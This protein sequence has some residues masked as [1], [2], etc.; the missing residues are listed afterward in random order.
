MAMQMSANAA[1]ELDLQAFFLPSSVQNIGIM[2][3]FCAGT[4][5]VRVSGYYGV[6][7]IKVNRH[8]KVSGTLDFPGFVHGQASG[9]CHLKHSKSRA[10]LAITVRAETGQERHLTGISNLDR[11]GQVRISGTFKE[12]GVSYPW[13]AT[14]R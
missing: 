12:G 7:V 11:R 8:G 9:T 4:F 14:R 6:L 10:D 2:Q 3:N 5:D 13:V 1:E